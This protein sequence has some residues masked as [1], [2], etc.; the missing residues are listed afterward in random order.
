MDLHDGIIQSIYAVGLTLDDGRFYLESDPT[1]A[2]GRMDQA[3]GE[4]DTVIA[5]L[6][7]YIMNLEPQRF[8]ERD[9]STGLIELARE[10]RASSFLNVEV[11]V[12]EEA[13]TLVSTEQTRELLHITKEALA[14][15]HRHARGTS[16]QI[17]LTVT[18]FGLRLTITDDGVGIDVTDDS[19]EGGF[20]LIN[21]RERADQINGNLAIDSQS[22]RGTM[23]IVELTLR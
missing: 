7:S 8:R 5:D 21:M 13:A 17:E 18:D 9:I 19:S 6:R 23:I 1:R 12:D 10:L 4:L 16:V 15:A 3:I 11:A 20:G 22:G 14:N 2:R